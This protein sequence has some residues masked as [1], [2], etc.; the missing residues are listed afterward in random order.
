MVTM[1][2]SLPEPM[3]AWVEK[4]AA[5]GQFANASDYVRDLIRHDQVKQDKIARL[6]A[7]V[8][9]GLASGIYEG[10]MDDIMDEAREQNGLPKRQ[11]AA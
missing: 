4:Q 5:S 7:L 10:T 11:S 2:I 1:N 6:K 3:K 8:D 9:E